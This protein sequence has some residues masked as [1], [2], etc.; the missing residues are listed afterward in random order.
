MSMLITVLVVT[1]LTAVPLLT[2]SA[3]A[4]SQNE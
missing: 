3:A 4:A 2:E 1:T